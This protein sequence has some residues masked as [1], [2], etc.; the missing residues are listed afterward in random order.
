MIYEFANALARRGHEVH[1][2]HVPKWP[3]RVDSVHAITFSF[4]PGMPHH[5]VATIHDPGVP[6]SDVVFPTPSH[7]PGDYVVAFL[8]LRLL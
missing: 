6:D 3:N 8:V 1:F 7:L 2:V 5:S 4:P